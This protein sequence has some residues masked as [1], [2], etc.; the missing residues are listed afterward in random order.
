MLSDLS[1]RVLLLGVVK[2][3]LDV[4]DWIWLHQDLE[5]GFYERKEKRMSYVTDCRFRWVRALL[6]GIV[7]VVASVAISA[8]ASPTVAQ[9]EDDP[10]YA[11]VSIL[12][13]SF[14]L[15][16]DGTVSGGCEIVGYRCLKYCPPSG[17]CCSFPEE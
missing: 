3:C 7:L 14:T 13:C 16:D 4:G 5:A 12:Q 9:T 17:P 2:S 8:D 6:T 1:I 11:A 10:G 15:D